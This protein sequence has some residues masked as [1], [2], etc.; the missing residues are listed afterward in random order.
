[1]SG[2]GQQ[3][4]TRVGRRSQSRTAVSASQSPPVPRAIGL[5]KQGRIGTTRPAGTLHRS[6]ERPPHHV[7]SRRGRVKKPS[8]ASTPLVFGPWVRG[9]RPSGQGPGSFAP[10]PGLY[11]RNDSDGRQVS[12]LRARSGGSGSSAGFR[13]PD[14]RRI[15]CCRSTVKVRAA[16]SGRAAD[17]DC[18]ACADPGARRSISWRSPRRAACKAAKAAC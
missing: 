12:P 5:A 9:A 14:I 6:V 10:P 13:L 7:P 2:E 4:I 11:I 1:M 8:K 16:D 3:G 17:R 15:R 18:A